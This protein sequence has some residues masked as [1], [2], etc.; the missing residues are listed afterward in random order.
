M[1]DVRRSIPLIRHRTIAVSDNLPWLRAAPPRSVDLVYA[2]PPFGSGRDWWAAEGSAAEGAVFSDK[3]EEVAPSHPLREEAGKI[4]FAAESVEAVRRV[5]GAEVES[6][7][8]FLAPRLV[9]IK[10]VLKP[11]GAFYLHH[12]AHQYVISFFFLFF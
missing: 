3:W 10:R 12:A 4:P 6:Y 5:W 11:S 1:D 2:D 8:L 7:V 9:E